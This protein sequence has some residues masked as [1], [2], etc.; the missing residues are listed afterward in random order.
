MIRKIIIRV[1]VFLAVATGSALLINKVNNMGLDSVSREVDEPSLPVVYC[2]LG[3]R[4]VNMMYGYTQVMSTSLMRDGIIPVNDDYGVNVLV[5][6]YS[7]YGENFGYELR[8]ISG[9]NLIENGE[10][11][12]GVTKDGFTEYKV[13]FRMDMNENR[14]YVFVFIVTNE[15]GES[16]RYYTRVVKLEC[17]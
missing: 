4:T 7:G 16:A 2:K 15:A 9:D 12:K 3:E 17:Q 5:A 13:H 6:D 10:A 1:I 8:S 11:E 14:E